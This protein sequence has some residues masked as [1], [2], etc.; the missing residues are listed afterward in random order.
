MQSSQ[1]VAVPVSTI[2]PSLLDVHQ[3]AEFL[4]VSESFIR[5]HESELPAVR[6]G[7]VIRFDPQLISAKF[8]GKPS[9]SGGSS[10]K[11]LPMDL[12]R[13]Q[14]GSVIKRGK[15]QTWYGCYR[16]DVFTADGKLERGSRQ[17]RL[18]KVS[19]LT[20]S[21]ALQKLSQHI[22]LSSKPKTS[23][24]FSELVTRWQAAIVPTL[25]PTTA[26][27]YNSGLKVAL[28]TFGLTPINEIGRYEIEKFL[29]DK[30]KQ[31]A[32]NT[33]REIRS[34]LSTVLSWAVSCGWIEK[35]PCKGVKLPA[36]TGNELIRTVLKPEQVN[37]LSESVKEPYATLILFLYQTGLRI[38]EAVAVKW[39]DFEAN[40][41]HI[42]RRIY[43]GKVG[44]LK[45][46]ASKR[47]LP[48]PAS[49]LTRLEL[50]RSKSPW[51]FCSRDGTPLS[52][53]NALKRHVQPAASKLGIVLGGFH[54]LRH[55]HATELMRA[56]VSPKV[57]S[58][59]LGH[60]NISVTLGTYSHP[61]TS[62]YA[63]PLNHLAEQMNGQMQPDASK[64]VTVN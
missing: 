36:G 49:L 60:S 6:L 32:K 10:G 48:I 53:G 38:G 34:S 45:T 50:L 56:G 27:V 44:D 14:R 33:L 22:A 7:R 41:L 52:P 12:K 3:T 18:G 11:V 61:G 37:L 20:K 28:K 62:D 43:D 54:D 47:S 26:T 17:I 30:A 63:Q 2:P 40:V 46:K 58:N 57:V 39:A 15:V 64:P 16:E 51:V 31:Y 4:N 23:V 35:N 19:E 59:I 42:Q 1:S 55:S 21:A 25:K 24:T 13:Y 5:R 29:A 9:A 8:S